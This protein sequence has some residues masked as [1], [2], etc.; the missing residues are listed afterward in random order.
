MNWIAMGLGI[1]GAIL[2]ARLNVLG[3]FAW[4][5]ANSLWIYIF[6]GNNWPAVGQFIAF[7]AICVMGI[8]RWAK[9]LRML[10]ATQ[11]IRMS[12]LRR[13]DDSAKPHH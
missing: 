12:Q 6:W 13:R 10:N 2:N 8:L 3:F 4:I 7:N 9:V 11:D 1:L 5:V